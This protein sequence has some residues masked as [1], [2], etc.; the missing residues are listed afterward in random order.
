MGKIFITKKPVDPFLNNVS[1]LLPFDNNFQDFSNNNFAVTAFGNAAISNVESKF[2]GGSVYFDGNGDYLQLSSNSAF[3]FGTGDFTVEMWINPNAVGSS[4]FGRIIQCGNYP[5]GWQL[6]RGTSGGDNGTSNPIQLMLDFNGGSPRFEGGTLQNNQWSHIAITRQSGLVRVFVNGTLSTSGTGTTDLQQYPLVIGANSNGSE[7]INAYIDDLRITKGVARYT[8]N[9]T[10][11]LKSGKLNIQRAGFDTF[12][13]NVSLLL[14]MNTSFADFSSN[15]FAVTAFGNAQ[16]SSAQS[17]FGGSSALFDGNGDYLQLPVNAIQFNADDFTI[18]FWVYPTRTG[19]HTCVAN[20]GCGSNMT[21]FFGV[22]TSEGVQVYL[23]GTGPYIGG[24]SI[25]ANQ[26]QHVALVR[27]GGNLN[28]YINGLQVDSYNIGNTAIDTVVD[29]IRIG[30]DTASF[31]CNTPLEGYMDDLRITTGVARYTANFTPPGQL[32]NIGKLNISKL[33]IPMANLLA[34]WKLNDTSDSS[35]NSNNLTNNNGVVFGE[36]GVVG[37][38]AR[39]TWGNSGS[40]LTTN[41][42]INGNA[43]LSLWFRYDSLPVANPE[44]YSDRYPLIFQKYPFCAVVTDP[45]YPRKLIL[46]DLATW[47]VT[48]ANE[49]FTVGQWCH[50]VTVIENSKAKVYADGVLILETPA[51]YTNTFESGGRLLGFGGDNV[52]LATSY[53][54]DTRYDSIGMWNRALTIKEIQTLYNNGQGLEP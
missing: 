54:T 26:W 53:G 11:E 27:Q 44:G 47:G 41:L 42:S 12:F 18:E 33:V 17:K 6:V 10:P 43:T 48:S 3:A 8:A 5:V 9:F 39:T 51:Q 19:F 20:W 24:G 7:N 2:G 35:G 49:V 40:Y 38:G 13:N 4:Q 25:Q 52:D 45:N 30:R 23:N 14:P 50:I 22:G 32:L 31:D 28:A 37:N 1:L 29:S 34:F 36:P 46:T 21:I 16:I 15:N